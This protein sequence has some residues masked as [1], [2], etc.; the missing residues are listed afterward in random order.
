MDKHLCRLA[1]QFKAAHGGRKMEV[2]IS[3]PVPRELAIVD[4]LKNRWP[5]PDSQKEVNT[6]VLVHEKSLQLGPEPWHPFRPIS[7]W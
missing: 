1:K 4:Q 7:F 3:V 6:V 2:M 5:M